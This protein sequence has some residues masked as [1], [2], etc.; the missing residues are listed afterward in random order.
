MTNEVDTIIGRAEKDPVT[1]LLTSLLCLLF[2]VDQSHWNQHGFFDLSGITVN[3]RTVLFQHT[4]F[5]FEDV[6]SAWV[7]EVDIADVGILG[8]GF[9]RTFF[10]VAT[11]KNRQVR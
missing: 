7:V 1:S 5:M 6:W 10:P 9:E 3:I 11:D 4:D 8:A 2:V